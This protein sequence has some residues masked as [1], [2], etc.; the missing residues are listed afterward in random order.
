MIELNLRSEKFPDDIWT[1]EI[2]GHWFPVLDHPGRNVSEWY[3]EGIYTHRVRYVP[4]WEEDAQNYMFCSNPG[5]HN[6]VDDLAHG[7]D[8]A[9]DGPCRVGSH[10]IVE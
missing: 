6:C 3:G 5:H 2:D 4:P 9:K 8:C 10:R 1:M 7:K